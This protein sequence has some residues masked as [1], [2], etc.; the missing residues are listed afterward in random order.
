L[1]SA[2]FENSVPLKKMPRKRNSE[3]ANFSITETGKA[4]QNP[5]ASKKK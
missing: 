1:D 2:R 5:L 3:K 4:Y